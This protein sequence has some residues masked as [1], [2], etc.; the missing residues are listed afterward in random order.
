MLR[1]LQAL[2][3]NKTSILCKPLMIPDLPFSLRHCRPRKHQQA[4][5]THAQIRTL[6]HSVSFPVLHQQELLVS[7]SLDI[8]LLVTLFTKNRF[9]LKCWIKYFAQNFY[10]LSLIM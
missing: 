2:N 9:Q 8:E 4:H 7:L 10:F 3:K 1:E 5:I 6:L